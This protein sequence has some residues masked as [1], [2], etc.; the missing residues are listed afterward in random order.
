MPLRPRLN[1]SSQQKIDEAVELAAVVWIQVVYSAAWSDA[2]A[3]P[4][5]SHTGDVISDEI[6][7][8]SVSNTFFVAIERIRDRLANISCIELRT[9][10]LKRGQRG[11]NSPL[12]DRRQCS[13]IIFE[14]DGALGET[15]AQEI[16]PVALR[17]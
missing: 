7:N 5:E 2:M 15:A 1:H 16:N 6:G 3:D 9:P 14:K 12:I 13:I 11:L 4:D 17:Q 10:S 8:E